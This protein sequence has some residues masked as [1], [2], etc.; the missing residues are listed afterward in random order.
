MALFMDGPACTVDDLAA[1]DSG[2]LDTAQSESI[3]VGRKIL[4]AVEEMTPDLQIWLDRRKY[5]GAPV[6][7]PALTVQQIV[8]TPTL[9]RWQEMVALSLVYRD[10]YF[11]HLVDRYQAKWQAYAKLAAEARE[12]FVDTG[13]ALVSM[14]VPRAGVPV[15]GSVAGPQA[16]G[17]FYACVSWMNPQ[18]QEGQASAPGS[19]TIADGNVM[20]ITPGSDYPGGSWNVY[21]GASLT[22]LYLQNPTLLGN[23]DLWSFIPGAVSTGPTASTGQNPDYVIPLIRTSLRG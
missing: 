8:I 1:H 19:L 10:A 21:A 22:A 16:G 11:S 2:L 5:Y 7:Q 6:W 14:P 13:M 3:D 9:R 12:R 20:T 17:T 15:L 18:G 4:L 23:G